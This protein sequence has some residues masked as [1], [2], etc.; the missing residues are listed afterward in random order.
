L[1]PIAPARIDLA[2]GINC[3]PLQIAAPSSS[4]V[5]ELTRIN[6]DVSSNM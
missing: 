2:Q 6:A 1:A 3:V 4:W 5:R